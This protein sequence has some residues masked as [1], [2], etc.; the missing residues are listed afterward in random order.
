[1]GYCGVAWVIVWSAGSG[2]V[3]CGVGCVELFICVPGVAG[4]G[5]CGSNVVVF[6]VV[7]ALV[8]GSCCVGSS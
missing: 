3:C 5:G 8:R 1:M 6:C 4:V 7:G 2:L